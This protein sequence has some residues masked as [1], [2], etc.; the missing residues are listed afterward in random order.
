M[1]HA[2]IKTTEGYLH[3]AQSD[4]PVVEAAKSHAEAI[5]AALDAEVKAVSK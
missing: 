4:E 1:G 5:A 3:F 2:D